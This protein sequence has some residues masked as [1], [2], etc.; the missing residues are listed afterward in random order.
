[1]TSSEGGHREKGTLH[2][3][4]CSGWGAGA[5][6]RVSDKGTTASQHSALKGNT[7]A[8]QFNSCS[9]RIASHRYLIKMLAYFT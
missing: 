7:K 5:V 3:L 6:G 8:T 9:V 2:P 1:M 4:A